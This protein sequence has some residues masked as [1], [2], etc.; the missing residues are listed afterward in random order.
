MRVGG[1]AE[2]AK[3]ELSVSKHKE[4]TSFDNFMK[5]TGGCPRKPSIRKKE[6]KKTIK[7]ERDT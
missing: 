7:K 1:I 4:I 2:F 6:P 5:V 3:I